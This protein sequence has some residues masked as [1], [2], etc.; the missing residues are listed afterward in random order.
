LVALRLSLAVVVPEHAHV[1]QKRVH[2]RH[3]RHVCLIQPSLFRVE[4]RLLLH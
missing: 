3:G 2:G 1:V 4:M